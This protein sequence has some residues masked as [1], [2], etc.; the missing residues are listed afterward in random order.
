MRIVLPVTEFELL[1]DIALGRLPSL[2]RRRMKRL[3]SS[4]R[5]NNAGPASLSLYQGEP[6]SFRGIHHARQDTI[7]K[8][9]HE[10]LSRTRTQLEQ[11]V[12]DTVWHEIAHHFGI[13]EPR[14]AAGR[15]AEGKLVTWG[16]TLTRIR[17]LGSPG[18][19]T[20]VLLHRTRPL[21]RRRPRAG[22]H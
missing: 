2:F 14:G 4:A 16:V 15:A 12:A 7:F 11:M 21:Y 18:Q 6:L 17:R 13:D 19:P 10:R 20:D 5:K 8:G 9:P 1:V 22:L 3:K